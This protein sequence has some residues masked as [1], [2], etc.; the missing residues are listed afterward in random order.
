MLLAGEILPRENSSCAFGLASL[1]S[2][3]HSALLHIK[4]DFL[5][6]FIILGKLL[7]DERQNHTQSPLIRQSR[8][9]LTC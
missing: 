9:Q 3:L 5:A 7:E 1:L 8:E 6:F 2:D 4:S